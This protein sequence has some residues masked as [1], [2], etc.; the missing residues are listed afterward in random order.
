MDDLPSWWVTRR[1]AVRLG[2]ID[3]SPM[4]AWPSEADYRW[5]EDWETLGFCIA[6]VKS[7]TP[8]EVLSD[9]V[10]A[11][12]TGIVSVDE[13]RRWAY[14]QTGPSYGTAIEAGEVGGWTLAVEFNG[15]QAT[16]DNVLRRISNGT[17]AVVL[18]RSVNADMSLQW[19]LD[20][21]IIRWFDP[22]LGTVWEGEPLPE[23]AGLAFGL[24]HAMSSALAC[25]ERLSGVHLTPH[26]LED[27]AGWIAIGHHP[28][29]AN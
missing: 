26:R 11:P 21:V 19:A 7:R 12:P 28:S 5:V 16:M 15:Y 9:L 27:R 13:A 29:P 2:I 4:T 6:L 25:A 23:E 3:V 18:Y 10:I 22:L 24:G 1:M 14:A 17:T 8:Q 20:G